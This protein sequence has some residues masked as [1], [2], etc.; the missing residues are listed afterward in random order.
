MN[1]KSLF[2]LLPLLA[3]AVLAVTSVSVAETVKPV[4]RVLW[5]ETPVGIEKGLAGAPRRAGG[6][7]E[8][9]VYPIGN[10]RLGCTVFG[11]PQKDRIQFN[12]DSLWVGNEDCTG[13]YQPFGDVYVEMPHSDYTD[14]R[15]ELD[16]SRAVQ[17]IAYRS[18]GVSYKREYFS[19]HPAQVMVFR[20]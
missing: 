9:S 10:G 4:N 6:S 20:F 17:T 8:R 12:E 14:Y 2:A 3:A 18:G 11:E 13:G 1:T 5:A 16:I 7:W 19:S 15:R